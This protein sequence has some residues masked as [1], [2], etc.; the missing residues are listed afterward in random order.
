MASE[1]DCVSTTPDDDR[2]HSRVVARQ[3]TS[4]TRFVAGIPAIGLFICAVALSIATLIAVCQVVYELCTG[5][6][7]LSQMAIEFIT[8]ADLFLLAV[9][10]YILSLG[11]ICLFVSD[12]IPL[13]SWL[14][15]HDFD[16]LK[17]RLASVICIMLGVYFLGYI[18]EGHT[19][20]DVLWLGLGSAII[21]AA[22]GFFVR[23]VFL[24]RD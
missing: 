18:L 8:Y 16:D 3:I 1:N 12:R 14:E 20:I 10:L 22:L 6:I 9:A 19:G 2:R 15:F 24:H 23:N 17:E 4:H 11:L 7:D 5:S 13:P 21:I